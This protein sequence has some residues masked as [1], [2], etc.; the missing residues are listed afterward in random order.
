MGLLQDKVALVTGGAKS[1]G[2]AFATTLAGEGANVIIADIVPGE[3]AAEDLNN[4]F[5]IQAV[6]LRAD[7]S[8]EKE[9]VG[10]VAAAVDAFGRIDILVNNA[11]FFATMPRAPIEQTDVELFDKVLAVNVRGPFLMVKHVAPHMKAA[12]GGKIINIGSGTANKGMPGMVA[13]VSSKAAMLGFTRTLSRELG[14]HGICV[15]TLSPGLI[16]SESLLEN[17]HHLEGSAK[18]IATR[19][20]QRKAVPD[21]LQGALLFLASSL[22]DFVTG[23]TIAV[24]GGSVNT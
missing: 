17:P 8:D 23:Q 3:P 10:L 7:V 1:I 16:E 15:N 2:R 13:Y 4:R 5:G 21:D 12:G 20:L 18:V 22:S 6:A 19:A 9:V 11:A 14:P 24:D